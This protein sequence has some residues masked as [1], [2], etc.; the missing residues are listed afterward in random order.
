MGLEQ[1]ERPEPL[2]PS[3]A[4]AN[5]EVIA[6]LVTLQNATNGDVAKSAR[7][8]KAIAARVRMDPDLRDIKFVQLVRS[9]FDATTY[10]DRDQKPISRNILIQCEVAR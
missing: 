1:K 9:E 7:N 5:S 2:S 6:A 3:I 4:A 10:F 8:A